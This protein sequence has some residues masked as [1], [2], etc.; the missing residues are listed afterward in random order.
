MK[1]LKAA[2]LNPALLYA[3]G[4]S[5]GQAQ[6]SSA[7]QASAPAVSQATPYNLS[8]IGP[9]MMQGA[10]AALSMRN[11]Q[12]D[13][14]VKEAQAK[15]IEAETAK[16]AGVDT[17]VGWQQ[18]RLLGATTE[19][20]ELKNQFQQ[21]ENDI[22]GATE[23]TQI[24]T[25]KEQL[26]NLM[27]NT[28]R[29][30]SEGRKAGV[31]AAYEEVRILNDLA[32]QRAELTAKQWGVK[33][34]EQQITRL[35]DMTLIDIAREQNEDAARDLASRLGYA[36]NEIERGRN[37]MLE[38]FYTGTLESQQQDRNNAIYIE[39]IRASKDIAGKIIDNVGKWNPK[40]I[41]GGEEVTTTRS[42]GSWTRT[43]K[44]TSQQ[45]R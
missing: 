24:E 14:A 45:Y 35:R 44:E 23:A 3:K 22:Q 26:N 10:Q 20:Q 39:G 37:R 4:G 32:L 15:Q 25:A 27:A 9:M 12:A 19:G 42:D 17:A 7:A 5:G 18:F 34:N 33:L 28:N 40:D 43:S 1:Q 8:G 2:G 13:I 11:T 16:T 31:Q 6:A 21:V 29:A 41:V 38:E 36:K 30:I